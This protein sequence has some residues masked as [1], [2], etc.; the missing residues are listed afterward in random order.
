MDAR[1]KNMRL[2]SIHRASGCLIRTY[3]D[4]QILQDCSCEGYNRVHNCNR[5][6]QTVQKMGIFVE[7]AGRNINCHGLFAR[8]PVHIP[9]SKETVTGAF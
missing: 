6:V 7:C 2:S 9:V 5:S 4:P 3:F 8:Q 1:R